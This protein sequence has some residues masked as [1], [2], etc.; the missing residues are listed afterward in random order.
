MVSAIS[1]SYMGIGASV[2]GINAGRLM[3]GISANNIANSNTE[4]YHAWRV[5][6]SPQAM[7]GVNASLSE[8]PEAPPEITNPDG[9]TSTLSNVDLIEEIT[10]LK[11]GTYMVE[12]NAVA[13]K[14]Q[15]ESLG[16]IIDMMA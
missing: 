12:A 4:N 1:S 5:D 9:S 6:L 11:M 13:L 3:Q 15:D 2:S 7:G 8:N 14:V 10:N 16:T